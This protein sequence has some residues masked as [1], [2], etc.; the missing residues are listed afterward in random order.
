[1]SSIVTAVLKATIGWLV[2]KG[3]DKAA[4]KLK[5]GDVTDKKIRDLIVRE[6]ADIKSK[7]DA[8]AKEKLYTA[9]D[10]FQVGLNYLY[11]AI[12]AEAAAATIGARKRN[13]NLEEPSSPS[14]TA[15]VK[16]IALAAEMTNMELTDFSEKTKKALSR[17]KMARKKATE[18][19]NN[20]ALSTFDRITAI[21]YR[22]MATMLES[23]VETVV[24]AS[25]LSS[26]SVKRAMENALP[27]CEQCLQKLHS[28]PDVKD[29]FKVEL[30]KS[31]LNIKGRFGKDER[32]EIISTVCQVNRAIYDAAQIANKDV[33]VFI[34]PSVD[35]GTDKIDPLRD[36]RVTEVL[37]KVDMEHCCVTPW[38]FGQ[39]GEE[40][41]KLKYPWDIATNTD[42]QFIIADDWDQTVKVFSSSGKFLHSFKTQTDDADTKLDVLDVTTNLN[43]SNIY[44]LVELQKP[45]AEGCELEM[46]VYQNSGD[47]LNEFHLI[48]HEE[49]SDVRNIR[50][51]LFSFVRLDKFPVMRGYWGRLT[52]SS[53]KVLVLGLTD[54]GKHV[55]DVFNHDGGYVCSFGEGI[56]KR[57]RDITTVP[58]GS[59]MVL[60]R[61]DSCVHVFTEDGT[62]LNKFNIN[63]KGDVYTMASHPAGEHVV[64]ACEERGTDRPRVDICTKDGEFVR[65]IALDEERSPGLGRITVTMEGHIAVPVRDEDGNWKVIVI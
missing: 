52:V 2:N 21:Q 51:A 31:V 36:G 65:A 45:G 33:H 39:E 60:D 29:N 27:E 22:V 38:S 43:N 44:V 46:H 13:E 25:N 63:T 34:W 53:N 59:V 23:A 58:D 6:I 20:E 17:F 1:M 41:H 8:L 3:R 48:H 16:T 28:L 54:E 24:T 10:A 50:S 9:I 19:T 12:D 61:G 56:L 62:Q 49:S 37:R 47:R 14:T 15:T 11:Q 32:R 57:A 5:E 64:I 35:I 7:L 40:E 55:V 42:R 18:A 4:E 26:L 30:E